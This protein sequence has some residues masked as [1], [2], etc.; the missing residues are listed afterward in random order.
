MGTHQKINDPWD[1][2]TEFEHTIA[3]YCGSKYAVACDSNT[4]AIRLVLHYLG[5]QN[6]KIRIPARTY[7]SVPNQ[8]IL[9][10]NTPVFVD[11]EW[12]GMYR[13]GD[14]PIVDAATAFYKGMY[15]EE[16]TILSFHLKKI[17]NIGTGGM[18]LTNDK[19]FER[20]ARPMIYDGRHKNQMYADDQFEC[21]GWHMYMTPEQA[22]RGLEIFHSDRIKTENDSVG[23]SWKYKDLREQKIYN[24]LI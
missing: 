8:I 11:V 12:E 15:Q 23:G 22:K 17:L 2:V 4:N 7:V 19:E 6:Q 1:W 5:I 14:T 21:V 13:I 18:I 9:S 10:G 16:Y 3:K 24:G 20:W